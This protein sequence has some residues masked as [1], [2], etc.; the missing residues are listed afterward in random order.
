LNAAQIL[1]KHFNGNLQL[2]INASQNELTQIDDI[3][4]IM[5][6][7]INNYFSI[8]YNVKNIQRCLDAGIQFSSPKII[9]NTKISGK[10]FLF[11]GTLN[12]LSRLQAS[13]EIE[14]YGAI[15]SKTLN[16][17]IDYLIVG[18]NPG[19]KFKKAQNMDIKILNENDFTILINE[20]NSIK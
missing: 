2:I 7:S 17:K 20:L 16:K 8:N 3:G 14:Q 11:T 15:I 9:E 6:E 10:R 19:S 5:A 18:D 4:E 13:K 1:D 12:K